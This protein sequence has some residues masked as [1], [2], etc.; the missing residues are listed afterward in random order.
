MNSIIAESTLKSNA[1]TI[2][3]HCNLIIIFTVSRETMLRHTI[4]IKHFNSQQT[5]ISCFVNNYHIHNNIMQ[6]LV[7]LFPTNAYDSWNMNSTYTQIMKHRQL[8]T[9]TSLV[10]IEIKRKFNRWL[11]KRGH[12]CENLLHSA[13]YRCVCGI[14]NTN[15]F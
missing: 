1:I 4:I 10:H 2:T 8:G 6:I 15:I 3:N 13:S 11:N 9:Y 12:K 5:V 14:L 7:N